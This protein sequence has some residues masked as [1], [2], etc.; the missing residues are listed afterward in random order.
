MTKT[1]ER[2]NAM[3][4]S[5][6]EVDSLEYI[7]EEYFDDLKE[8]IKELVAQGRREEQERIADLIDFDMEDVCIRDIWVNDKKEF[9]KIIREEQARMTTHLMDYFAENVYRG[10]DD[11]MPVGYEFWV[12]ELEEEDMEEIINYYIEKYTDLDDTNPRSNEE[13]GRV[14]SKGG[15]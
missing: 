4:N 6:I 3:L 8:G 9:L 14:K 7:P 1:D 10:T 11:D 13:K 12:A 15:E 5:Y 2:I